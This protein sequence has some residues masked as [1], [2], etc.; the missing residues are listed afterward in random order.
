MSQYLE[1]ISLK[2]SLR[3]KWG[4]PDDS[5]VT[6]PPAMQE[7]QETWIQSLCWEDPL[8]KEMVTHSSALAWRIPGTVEPDGLLSMGSH[9]VGHD[10]SHLAAAAAAAEDTSNAQNSPSQTSAI[11]E[12]R[13]SRCSSWFQKRQR[14]Q[15]SNC[16]HPLHHW[17][18]MRVP[19]KHLLLLYWWRQSLWLCRSKQTGKFFKR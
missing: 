1:I 3:L 8:G 19:E 2:R 14:N 4:F 9:R 5:A 11:H 6:N 12:P 13:T 15:R 18:S 10:W 16:Q 17:K 7:N